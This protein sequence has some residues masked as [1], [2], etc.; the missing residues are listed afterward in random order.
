MKHRKLALLNFALAYLFSA[1]F[2][3]F[4]VSGAG[5]LLLIAI[6]TLSIVSLIM[7]G[8]QMWVSATK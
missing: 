1:Y 7:S 5:V 8:L 4:L 3:I 2:Q 6:A